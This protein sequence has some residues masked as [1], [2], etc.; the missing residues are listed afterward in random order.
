MTFY[1]CCDWIAAFTIAAIV[2][3]K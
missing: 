1:Q 3:K 2:N